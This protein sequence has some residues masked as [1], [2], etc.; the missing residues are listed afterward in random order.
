[1][2]GWTVDTA[3][4]QASSQAKDYMGYCDPAWVRD[5]TWR[6]TADRIALLTASSDEGG[7]DSWVL[8]GLIDEQGRESWA[9]VRGVIPEDDLDPEIRVRFVTDDEVVSERGAVESW[10]ADEGVRVLTVP[11]PEAGLSAL[12]LAGYD[13][14]QR[15]EPN[16]ALYEVDRMTVL[17][18][19]RN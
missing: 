6:A 5:C 19:G 13:V 7:P 14:I 12:P 8:Q 11:L 3:T 9:V 18:R 15:V 4:F 1:M 2:Q 17:E 16:G 10:L